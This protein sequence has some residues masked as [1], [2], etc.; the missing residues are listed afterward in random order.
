MT[1]HSG[2]N[3][4]KHFLTSQHLL[5]L[6]TGQCGPTEIQTC[7]PGKYCPLVG[8]VLTG[9]LPVSGS[10]FLLEEWMMRAGS[11]SESARGCLT[12]SSRLVDFWSSS[13]SFYG[14]NSSMGLSSR[15]THRCA[16]HTTDLCLIKS[17]TCSSGPLLPSHFVLPPFN[18]L[19]C[20]YSDHL[21]IWS[22]ATHCVLMDRNCSRLKVPFCWGC[23]GSHH[24][25]GKWTPGWCFASLATYQVYVI[26]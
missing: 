5:V 4:H 3:L 16:D 17:P 8:L 14:L 1:R 11:S 6:P 21:F 10:Q 2:T 7:W 25:P 26:I 9:L 12:K 23:T 15:C 22:P 13:N 19:L 20:I 24:R 18:I